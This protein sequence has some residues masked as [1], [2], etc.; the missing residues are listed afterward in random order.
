MCCCQSPTDNTLKVPEPDQ[1]VHTRGGSSSGD[2]QQQMPWLCRWEHSKNPHN[3]L[4]L[5]E[6]PRE[7]PGRR[8]TTHSCQGCSQRH[9]PRRSLPCGAGPRS[10]PRLPPGRWRCPAACRSG[11]GC[12]RLWKEAGGTE[13][14]RAPC[15]GCQRAGART[16]R[17][18]KPA[19]RWSWSS[20]P[21]TWD[22]SPHDLCT[23]QL[24]ALQLDMPIRVCRR[25][26]TTGQR[27]GEAGDALGRVENMGVCVCVLTVIHT[28]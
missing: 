25:G 23:P 17:S 2:A 22:F 27:V 20:N 15:C 16:L 8:G 1:R 13:S 19:G 14:R 5:L 4:L 3:L 21:P 28:V 7:A 18:E 9:S 10:L 24:Q 26:W 11:S 6:G 12:P